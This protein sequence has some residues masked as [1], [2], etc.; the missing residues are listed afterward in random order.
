MLTS[1]DGAATWP[2]VKPYPAKP[3]LAP[4]LV[5]RE[6]SWDLAERLLREAAAAVAELVR[7]NPHIQALQDCSAYADRAADEFDAFKEA[8]D[9]RVEVEPTL[10]Q[11]EVDAERRA[12][13]RGE[14]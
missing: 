1:D 3:L 10:A 5:L 13:L 12:A 14:A 9:G 2:Q 4:T 6:S 8:D 11:E 7:Q